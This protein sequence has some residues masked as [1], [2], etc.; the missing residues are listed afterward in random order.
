MGKLRHR[1]IL[2]IY[3]YIY[4][5]T[6][7][8]ALPQRQGF[9]RDIK[10]LINRISVVESGRTR[11]RDRENHSRDFRDIRFTRLTAIKRPTNYPVKHAFHSPSVSLLSA[12]GKLIWKPSGIA[13]SRIASSGITQRIDRVKNH[14][15][16]CEN[17]GGSLYVVE[18]KLKILLGSW[19]SVV[20]KL[21][22]KV[23]GR[24]IEIKF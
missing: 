2:Y 16:T 15:V 13:S 7:D 4:V 11:K 8:A 9:L 20:Q 21:K 12:R 10:F 19:T 3:I 6:R 17:D 18:E 24:I 1:V 5:D 23:G 14:W 22:F